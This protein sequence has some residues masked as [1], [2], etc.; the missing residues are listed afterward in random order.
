MLNNTECVRNVIL[1]V[2]LE[3]RLIGGLHWPSFPSPVVT[4]HV[5]CVAPSEGEFKWRGNDPPQES[6]RRLGI[7]MNVA[8]ESRYSYLRNNLLLNEFWLTP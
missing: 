8:S 1:I 6:I 7:C 3:L 2:S 5:T 4:Q